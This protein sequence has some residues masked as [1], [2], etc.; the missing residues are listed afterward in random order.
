MI[1]VIYGDLDNGK[2][3]ESWES[4]LGFMEMKSWSQVSLCNHK[5][6]A[7]QCI[8]HVSNLIE[9]CLQKYMDREEVKKVLFDMKK[10]KPSITNLDT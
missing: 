4:H 3:S 7:L 6:T 1:I 9:C 10:I 8:D 5:E 2:S